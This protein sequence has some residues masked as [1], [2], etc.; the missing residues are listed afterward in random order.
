VKYD[1]VYLQIRQVA[2]RFDLKISKVKIV[3]I[4]AWE[5]F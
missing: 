2:E 1:I 3:Y 5:V 4:E